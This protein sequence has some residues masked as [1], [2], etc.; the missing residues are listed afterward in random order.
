MAFRWNMGPLWNSKGG[1]FLHF[2]EMRPREA[3][4]ASWTQMRMWRRLWEG[5]RNDRGPL[6]ELAEVEEIVQMYLILPLICVE[7]LLPEF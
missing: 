5:G 1:Q 4:T 6:T 3:A 7:A 2:L